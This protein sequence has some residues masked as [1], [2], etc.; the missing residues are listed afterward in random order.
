MKIQFKRVALVATVAL[1]ML[2][3]TVMPAAAATRHPISGTCRSDGQWYISE[4]DRKVASSDTTI[5]ASFY[6][7]CV[8]TMYFKI[9]NAGTGAQIGSTIAASGDAQALATHVKAGTLIN[10]A[11]RLSSSCYI[12]Q[13]RDFAGYEWY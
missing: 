13:D 5:R 7:F 8:R 12:W 9:I 11:F 10:N 4:L 3:T 2:A 6:D 1:T